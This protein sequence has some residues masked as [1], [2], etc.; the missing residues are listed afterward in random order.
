MLLD[1]KNL[2]LIYYIQSLILCYSDKA[3]YQ[4]KLINK[5]IWATMEM[6]LHLIIYCIN[7]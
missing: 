4:Y 3:N 6:V 1:E 7:I 5:S 2:A